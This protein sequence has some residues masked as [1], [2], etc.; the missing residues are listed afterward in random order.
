[1]T[2]KQ[3]PSHEEQERAIIQLGETQVAP[4]EADILTSE[5]YH[6]VYRKRSLSPEHE[7]MIA[8][9]EQAT[10]E[11]Q[12]YSAAHN[13]KGRK[14]FADAEGW[15]LDGDTHWTFSFENICAVLGLDPQYLRQGLRRW[16]RE[17]WPK[18][19]VIPMNL[20]RKRQKM[21]FLAAA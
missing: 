12:K 9:L 17:R 14:L 11:F 16:K 20:R 3:I 21:R 19:S 18:R 13:S 5:E 7:L 2:T 6:K 10:A 1:M 4:F 15:F 8:V